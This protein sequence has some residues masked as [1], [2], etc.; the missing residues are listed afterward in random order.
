MCGQADFFALGTSLARLAAISIAGGGI[1][2]I[3]PLLKTLKNNSKQ[4][5]NYGTQQE[6]CDPQQASIIQ[7]GR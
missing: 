5:E 2:V 1:F 4:L 3:R 7:G 6:E